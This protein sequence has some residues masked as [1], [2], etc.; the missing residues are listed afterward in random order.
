MRCQYFVCI[1]YRDFIILSFHFS[2]WFFYVNALNVFLNS[3]TICCCWYASTNIDSV[4]GKFLVNL[5]LSCLRIKR[6]SCIFD[7]DKLCWQLLLRLCYYDTLFCYLSSHPCV[8]SIKSHDV[9]S[10]IFLIPLLSLFFVC[11]H[12]WVWLIY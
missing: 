4:F 5:T 10:H 7:F 8:E 3:S 2:K 11:I 1:C 6:H 12:I 9:C